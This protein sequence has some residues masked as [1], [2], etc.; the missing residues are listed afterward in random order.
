MHITTITPQP[1]PPPQIS[2][3]PRLASP[4]PPTHITLVRRPSPLALRAGALFVLYEQQQVLGREVAQLGAI[5][6]RGRLVQQGARR[7]DGV[8]VVRLVE[9]AER[10]RVAEGPVEP[11]IVDLRQD[12]LWETGQGV[13]SGGETRTGNGA[14]TCRVKNCTEF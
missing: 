9:L 13:V 10:L 12:Q 11:V 5:I 6:A 1:P 8:H 14:D 7:L 3:A 4:H 2:P